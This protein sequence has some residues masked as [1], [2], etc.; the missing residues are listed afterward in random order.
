MMKEAKKTPVPLPGSKTKAK[1]QSTPLKGSLSNELVGSDDDSSTEN[2]T[3]S[4]TAEKPKMTIAVHRPNGAVKSKTKST[5]EPKAAPKKPTPKKVA[6]QAQAAELSSSDQTDDDDATTRDIQTKLPGDA[7]KSG[8]AGKSDSDSSSGSSSDESDA[9][10]ALKSAQK[11]TQAYV[12]DV[13]S[14][15]KQVLTWRQ[16]SATFTDTTTR[17]GI[18]AYTGLRTAQRLQHCALEQQDHVEI[19]TDI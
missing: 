1:A 7:R 11:S 14:L 5:K 10:G 9:D 15:H 3:M 18:P 2:A 12:T 16:A 6:T 4:K 8:S 17:R 19:R 13:Q